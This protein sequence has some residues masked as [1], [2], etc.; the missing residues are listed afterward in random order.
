[1][2]FQALTLN[3]MVLEKKVLSSE[4][5]GVPEWRNSFSVCALADRERHFGHVVKMGSQWH[6]FDATRFNDE[7]NGFRSLGNFVSLQVAKK[8]TEMAC[9]YAR[10]LTVRLAGA[11]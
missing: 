2:R 6:A 7:G 3:P 4:C 11:A 1:M 10:D 8:A 9:L 5:P